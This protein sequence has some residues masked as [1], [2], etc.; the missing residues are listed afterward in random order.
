MLQPYEI[1]IL[2]DIGGF[3]VMVIVF[4]CLG[5]SKNLWARVWLYACLALSGIGSAAL[6]PEGMRRGDLDVLG[7]HGFW[8]ILGI[9]GAGLLWAEYRRSHPKQGSHPRAPQAGIVR[10]P[11]PPAPSEPKVHKITTLE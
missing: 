2:G 4:A 8:T 6:L 9:L 1:D 3:A 11:V 5:G 7:Y 10:N